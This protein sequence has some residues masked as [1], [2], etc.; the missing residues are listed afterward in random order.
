MWG[1]RKI[2]LGKCHQFFR[3]RIFNVLEKSTK[4]HFQL[5]GK[6]FLFYFFDFF[7]FWIIFSVSPLIS[8]RLFEI[9]SSVE[10][11]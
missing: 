5:F 7:S 10:K 11:S 3:L 8:N 2:F 6:N 4:T 1:K 9:E